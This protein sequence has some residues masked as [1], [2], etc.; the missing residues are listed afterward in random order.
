MIERGTSATLVGVGLVLASESNAG[1]A[2]QLA[3][4]VVSLI[5][6]ILLMAKIIFARQEKRIG[7]LE[8]A[9]QIQQVALDK[10]QAKALEE[11]RAEIQRLKQE[12]ARRNP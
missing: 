9:N 12:L 3:G 6:G 11:A 5:A 8:E 7:Q 4:G 10:I 2:I 1:V